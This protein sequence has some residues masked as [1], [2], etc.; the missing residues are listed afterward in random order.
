MID[1]K[2][3]AEIS[4]SCDKTYNAENSEITSPNFPQNYPNNEYC[5]WNIYAPRGHLIE[6]VILELEIESDGDKCSY[7]WLEFHD[8]GDKNSLDGSEVENRL[9]SN[10]HPNKIVSTTNRVRLIFKTDDVQTR[11]GFK[12]RYSVNSK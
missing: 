7:D 9:C 10:N 5:T 6:L 3:R 12:I 8:V 11:T 4:A 1:N 2:Q